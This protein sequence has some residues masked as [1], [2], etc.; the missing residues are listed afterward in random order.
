M[1]F[2]FRLSGSSAEFMEKLAGKFGM[3]PKEVVLDSLAILNMAIDEIERSGGKLG[4]Q[5][6]DGSFTAIITPTLAAAQNPAT[7][8]VTRGVSE[9]KAQAS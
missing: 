6:S 3:Q 4:I 9:T 8:R 1:R 5:G 7:V 2:N